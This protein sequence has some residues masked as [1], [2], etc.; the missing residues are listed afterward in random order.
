MECCWING[1]SIVLGRVEGGGNGV[2]YMDKYCPESLILLGS[3]FY[4]IY[5]EFLC[6]ILTNILNSP[7]TNSINT[8]YT[9]NTINFIKKERIILL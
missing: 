8:K 9:A 2:E 6:I 4:S 1:W 3:I 5:F 7:V